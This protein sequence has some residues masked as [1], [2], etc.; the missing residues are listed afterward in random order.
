MKRLT[1]RSGDD[2]LP[3]VRIDAGQQSIRGRPDARESV[4]RRSHRRSTSECPWHV[5]VSTRETSWVHRAARNDPALQFSDTSSSVFQA[6]A[7]GT[8]ER[9]CDD[10]R[11]AYQSFL[12]TRPTALLYSRAHVARTS[13]A[14]QRADGR[15]SRDRFKSLDRY[16]IEI[17]KLGRR[18]AMWFFL[19]STRLAT[20]SSKRIVANQ[21]TLHAGQGVGPEFDKQRFRSGRP[22]QRAPSL[23]ARNHP[24][25]RHGPRHP[26]RC[27]CRTHRDG[28]C[29]T[30]VRSARPFPPGD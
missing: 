1:A 20:P 23:L 24:E 10:S 19:S 21:G 13:V 7:E 5:H 12:G 16:R 9:M 17:E 18:V 30:V 8:F 4:L 26:L 22:R 6:S 29:G 25:P 2:G 28:V 15:R 14:R 27:R 11:P 3:R